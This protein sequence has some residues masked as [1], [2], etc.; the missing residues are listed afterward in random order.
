MTM[1]RGLKLRSSGEAFP[2]TLPVFSHFDTLSFQRPVTFFV[3]E[4]GSGKSTLLEIIAAGLRLPSLTQAAIEQ[5]PL[6]QS[7]REAVKGFRL[8]RSTPIKHG[9]FFRADDVTGFLQSIQKTQRAHLEVAAELETSI[10]GKR[11]DDEHDR[12]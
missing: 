3:G 6:M 8:I 4:N 7:A 10:H 9:F 5:H 12:P 2:F 1:L 11:G